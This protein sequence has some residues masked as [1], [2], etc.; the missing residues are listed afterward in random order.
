MET[1]A[2]LGLLTNIWAELRKAKQFFS[3]ND[4]AENLL[5]KGVLPVNDILSDFII[6]DNLYHTNY[7]ITIVD[8]ITPTQFDAKLMYFFIASPG[9]MLLIYIIGLYLDKYCFAGLSLLVLVVIIVL[10]P[11]PLLLYGDPRV[12]FYM[13]LVLSFCFQL[14]NFMAVI[15]HGPHMKRIVGEITYFEG[16]FESA[17]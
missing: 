15:F 6:A 17:P 5:F 7:N 13:A 4:F 1:H 11:V 16:K 2:V 9:F 12:V 10:V 14:V 3:I 8:Q